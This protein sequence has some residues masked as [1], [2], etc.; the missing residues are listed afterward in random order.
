[1]IVL[2]FGADELAIRRRLRELKEMAD[3]GTGML[4]TNLVEIE[5]REAKPRDVVDPA[6]VPPFLAPYRMV[7]VDHLL[8]RFE[9]RPGGRAG[10]ALGPW[11]AV[12]EGL[13]AGVPPS[14]ILVFVGRP[15]LAD[16]MTR[17]VTRQN[18][19]VAALAA[20]PEAV[21]EEHTAMK[22]AELE[23]YIREEAALRGIRFHAGRPA[24]GKLEA[25]EEPPPENDPVTLLAN[26]LNGDTLLIANEL[27]K[28]AL[29]SMGAA[30]DV[31]DAARVC[32]GDRLPDHFKM[33]DAMMDGDASLAM[34]MFT[35]R[36]ARGENLLAI[37]AAIAERYRSIAVLRDLLATGAPQEEIDRALGGAAR[38]ENLRRAALA[39]ARRF[40]EPDIRQAYQY[41]VEADRFKAG[42]IAH[43]VAMELLIVRLC[44]L[45][46][47]Q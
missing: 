16:H 24:A 30:V 43:D 14:T 13:A 21:V 26:T 29:W 45:G 9:G 46:R 11:Q 17:Q 31:L 10:R 3:G 20:L 7:V 36:V 12:P 35:R 2:L 39:R 47:R 6:M 4:V 22:R 15:F 40:S 37:H 28:L 44:T 38:F 32:G 23:R 8:E 27:D 1:M 42:E 18:P 25:W 41:L 19:M 33:V 34:E 5:A